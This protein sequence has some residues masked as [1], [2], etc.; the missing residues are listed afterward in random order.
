V[1][2]ELAFAVEIAPAGQAAHA[3][4]IEGL[5]CPGRHGA[6]AAKG[7]PSNPATQKH[8]LDKAGE[9]ERAGQSEHARADALALYLPGV[10]ARH[11]ASQ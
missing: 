11:Q 9:E 8:A 2:A 7:L 5:N 10:Q 3:P 6:Q 4:S 1:Q